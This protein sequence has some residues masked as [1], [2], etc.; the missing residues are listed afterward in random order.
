MRARPGHAVPASGLDETGGAAV[1][2][3]VGYAPILDGDLR[4][5]G[6]GRCWPG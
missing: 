4:L 2:V 3:T 1:I 6:A 5:R